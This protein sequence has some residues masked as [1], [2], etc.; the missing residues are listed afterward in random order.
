MWP[1]PAR[2]NNTQLLGD[3]ANT[4]IQRFRD[5]VFGPIKIQLTEDLVPVHQTENCY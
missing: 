3:E 5:V 4:Q 2:Y 1:A